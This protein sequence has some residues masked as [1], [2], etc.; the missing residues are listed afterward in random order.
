[1]INI[2]YIELA[3]GLGLEGHDNLSINKRDKDLL[4]S[5][6]VFSVEPG[7][8]FQGKYGIRVEDTVLVTDDGYIPLNFFNHDLIIIN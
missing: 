3:M 6:M 1:L 4:K 8:Y 7:V 2:L 5:G